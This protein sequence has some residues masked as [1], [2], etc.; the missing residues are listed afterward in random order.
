MSVQAMAARGAAKALADRC[1]ELERA[2]EESAM[3]VGSSR[4]MRDEVEVWQQQ[5]QGT[6]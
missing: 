5:L 4:R 1:A 6:S 2:L 3:A